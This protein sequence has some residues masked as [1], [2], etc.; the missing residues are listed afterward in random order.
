[1][2]YTVQKWT[3]I[4]PDKHCMGSQIC[5]RQCRRTRTFRL[6]NGRRD[7][8]S[9]CDQQ[10]PTRMFTLVGH[11]NIDRSDC[12][13]CK[14]IGVRRIS[15]GVVEAEDNVLQELDRQFE[16]TRIEL[17]ALKQQREDT[18]QNLVVRRRVLRERTRA[19]LEDHEYVRLQHT[20][21]VSLPTRISQLEAQFSELFAR[22]ESR[23]DDIVTA[24]KLMMHSETM[25]AFWHSNDWKWRCYTRPNRPEK[26]AFPNDYL[27]SGNLPNNALLTRYGVAK[28][29]CNWDTNPLHRP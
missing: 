2:C 16:Q 15:G 22:I 3:D 10:A 5:W 21:N 12:D 28:G 25:P 23:I 13:V 20:L 18:A 8:Y 4:C 11:A 27:E 29:I 19:Y 14:K 1:M 6:R 17:N 9:L 24:Q 7:F 26:E